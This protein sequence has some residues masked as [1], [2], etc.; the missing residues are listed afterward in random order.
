MKYEEFTKFLKQEEMDK[1]VLLL[2][3]EEVFLKQHCKTELLKRITPEQM[4]EFNVFSYDGRKYDIDGVEEAIEALP[5]MSDKKLLLFRNSAI[6]TISGKD[7]ATKEYKEYWEKRLADIPEDVYIVFDEDKVDKRSG[8][9]KRLLKEDAVAEFTYLTENKMINWTVGLFKTMGKQISPHD[10]KHL[11]EVTGEGMLA[12]K[13][14]A[15]KI[16][17][18][19]QGQINVTRADIDAVVIPVLENKVFEMVDAILARDAYTALDK[20]QDLC[21][22]KEE[23]IRILGAIS[24]SVDKIL[25]VKFMNN[26]NMDKTQIAAKSKIPP[27]LVSKYI[28]LSAKYTTESLENLLTKCVETDRMFKLTPA[29]KTVLLQ[30]FISDFAGKEGTS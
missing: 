25:T 9:Y 22:M 5:V 18:Y 8:L 15:E 30:R 1:N 23:E 11:V 6:F 29:D 21:A 28:A 26:S 10:A 27:F 24:S 2:F 14:E 3:G 16:K 20:L 12:V 19:T 4:P 7:A 17:A 13:Q